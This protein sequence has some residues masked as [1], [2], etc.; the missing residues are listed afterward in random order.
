MRHRALI[1][2]LLIVGVHN[3]F[4]VLATPGRTCRRCGNHAQH[5]VLEASRKFSLFFI[6]LF[7][8]GARRYYDTCPVCGLEV[9]LTEA[10]AQS[11]ATAPTWVAPQDSVDWTP[12]DRR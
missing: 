4:R 11:V 1:R 6:P 8:V 3:A 7:R 12:Q 10:E 2:V 5:E 9:E